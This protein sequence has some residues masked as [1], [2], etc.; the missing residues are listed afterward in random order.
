MSSKLNDLA[1]K[2]RG[3]KLVQKT[4]PRIIEYGRSEGILQTAQ[5]GFADWP[6]RTVITSEMEAF[7]ALAYF[8]CAEILVE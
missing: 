4:L 6:R 2:V 3:W 5:V 1:D 7:N 8:Y